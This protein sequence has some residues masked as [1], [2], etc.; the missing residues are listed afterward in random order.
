MSHSRDRLDHRSLGQISDGGPPPDNEPI[1]TRR[2]VVYAMFGL[3]VLLYLAFWVA[4]AV[5]FEP[6]LQF[7]SYYAINYDQ[8]FVRRGLAGELLRLFPADHYFTGLL[9]LRWLIPAL[10]VIGLAAVA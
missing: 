8:G 1:T 3:L 10:F 7:F 2:T 6:N 9:I 4:L 5:L